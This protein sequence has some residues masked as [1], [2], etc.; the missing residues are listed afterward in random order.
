MSVTG[1]YQRY[2]SAIIE[3]L[4]ALELQVGDELIGQVE[5]LKACRSQSRDHL[6]V[7][8]ERTLGA[9]EATRAASKRSGTLGCEVG[10]LE[11]MVGALGSI[12]RVILG[13]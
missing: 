7:A 1:E 3:L 13:R 8:A 4:D 6:E 5:V 2:L 11:E 9:L 10:R 12:C